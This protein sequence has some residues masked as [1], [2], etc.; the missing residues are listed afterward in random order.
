MPRST[1]HGPHE[2]DRTGPDDHYRRLL[3]SL[4]RPG[5][6]T[7]A[8][9]R[10]A[11]ELV[12]A[13]DT[14]PPERPWLALVLGLLTEADAPDAT[15]GLLPALRD[16]IDRYLALT[17]AAADEAD[18]P[19]LFAL[20]YLLGHF[21]A[22]RDRILAGLADVPVPTDDLARLERELLPPDP[23]EPVL[24][25]VWPS[26]A[27]WDLDEA[28]RALDR[29]WMRTLPA[30]RF[31]ALWEYDTRSLLAYS[32]AKALWA[33]EHGR[34]HEPPSAAPGPGTRPGHR[35]GAGSAA[36]DGVPERHRAVLRCPVCG[37]RLSFAPAAA[38]CAGCGAAHPVA[39]GVLDLSA[40]VGD[41][42]EVQ[43]RNVPPRYETALRPAFLRLMGDNWNAAVTIADEDRYLRERVRP[44]DGPVL[45]LAAG[46]GRWTGTLARALG[47]E[48]VIGLD[49]SSS[50][51][52]R[53]H[54][55]LP[56]VLAVRASALA[57]PFADATLGAVNCWNALQAI[58]DPEKAISEVGRCLRPNGTFTLF[59]F[60][61]TADPIV[62]HFQNRVHPGVS[63]PETEAVHE[64][65][66][67]SGM[68][69]RNQ[70]CPGNFLFL[71][72][73]REY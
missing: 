40:G 5:G 58:P 36:A 9:V 6:P 53:L 38:V 26:P 46:A 56:D 42:D 32:G 17:A 19:L 14:R 12:A 21:P 45:D 52:G 34:V 18:E 37:G 57:L 28:E 59:T 7:P 13:L 61:P 39:E 25:R 3:P 15:P 62:R 65:L 30:E 22:D 68:T 66:A 24:G 4:W 48:R 64:W 2:A 31:T 44:A 69:V 33:V 10:S 54:V 11:P 20:L 16:G 8:G 35:A 43:K 41:G 50:M 51:L 49:L 72:A 47:P 67:R 23:A 1:L 73:V 63:V 27:V 60:R 29:E 55:S 71:T 70:H